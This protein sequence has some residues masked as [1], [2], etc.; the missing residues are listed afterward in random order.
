MA[1]VEEALE[2]LKRVVEELWPKAKTVEGALSIRYTLT[3]AEA[4]A[5]FAKACN[6]RLLLDWL[7]DLG[8]RFGEWQSV[9]N[10]PYAD[11]MKV[12]EALDELKAAINSVL[13]ER[14]E[15]KLK[16]ET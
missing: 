2:R 4:A 16:I 9:E 15:C 6:L 7:Q 13:Q 3:S 10:P 14:C 5:K 1:K 12:E 11:K 8:R